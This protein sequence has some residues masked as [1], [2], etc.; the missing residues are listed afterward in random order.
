MTKESG[1]SAKC[2]RILC[3]QKEEPSFKNVQDWTALA[4]EVSE[5]HC[6]E[7]IV[8]NESYEIVNVDMEGGF[9][10][11]CGPPFGLTSED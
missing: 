10:W 7:E 11:G 2:G 1:Y 9:V 6:N 4:V 3:L 5:G 8:D